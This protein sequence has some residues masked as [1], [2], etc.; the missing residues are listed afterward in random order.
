[1]NEDTNDDSIIATKMDP[2]MAQTIPRDCG[3]SGYQRKIHDPSVWRHLQEVYIETVGDNDNRFAKKYANKWEDYASYSGFN[4]AVEVKDDGHRGR[5]I[6]A[7]EPIRKGTKVWNSFHLARFHT[8]REMK[9]FLQQLDHDLRCDALLWAYVEKG[10]GYVALAL[11]PASFVNHGETKDVINLDA[12]CYAMRDIAMGEELLEDYSHF[13]G[14]K[15]NE[16]EWFHRMRGISWKEEQG[17]TSR[18]HSATEYNV[19]G[20]PKTWGS[21]GGLRGRAEYPVPPPQ[22]IVFCLSCLVACLVVKKFLPSHFF[23]KQK[24]GI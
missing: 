12:D 21:A 14:F 18:S 6:Y 7:A 9:D 13:I 24:G 5:S 23:K 8:P 22:T 19:L 16:V 10:K 1:M 15:N 4:V 17:P 11:D 2:G 3:N 20:A